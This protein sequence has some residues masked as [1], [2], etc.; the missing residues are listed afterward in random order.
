MK[1][2]K[3]LCETYIDEL[4]NNT[5][6]EFVDILIKLCLNGYKCNA[7]KFFKNSK[8]DQTIL[9]EHMVKYKNSICQPLSLFKDHFD[10]YNMNPKFFRDK[11]KNAIVFTNDELIRI[12]SMHLSKFI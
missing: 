4:T 7:I 5:A 9:W 6:K 3:L 2:V 12:L 11:V 10:F 1:S 8:I